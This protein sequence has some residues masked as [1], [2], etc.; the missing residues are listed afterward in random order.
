MVHRPFNFAIVDE[1]DSILIDEAR[2]PLIISGPTDDKSEL[3]IAVD[4]IVKQLAARGLRDRR[5]EQEHHLTEDGVEKAERMLE[6]PGCSK[7]RTS[8]MSRTRR[9][10]TTLTRR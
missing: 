3:Y 9:S 1:V 10:S 5:E 6:P 2:T 4:A 8:T 7:A